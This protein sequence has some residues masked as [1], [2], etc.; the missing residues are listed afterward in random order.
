MYSDGG[1]RE[2]RNLCFLRGATRY[3]VPSFPA[4]TLWTEA[5]WNVSA[6]VSGLS[7]KINPKLPF[8]LLCLEMWQR[9]LTH[10]SFVTSDSWQ[11]LCQCQIISVSL[12]LYKLDQGGILEGGKGEV[13]NPCMGP[14]YGWMVHP[15]APSPLSVCVV[16]F[17]PY[18]K[19]WL[20]RKHH[21]IIWFP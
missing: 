12:Y 1:K 3:K 2:I 11:T 18:I 14:F 5:A 10:A 15:T 19:I 16:P 9:K 17:T 4:A 6:S 7:W 21:T 8:P 20:F 13:S